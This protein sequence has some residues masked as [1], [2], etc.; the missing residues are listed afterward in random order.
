MER[1]DTNE[2]MVEALLLQVEKCL[3]E[4]AT[5]V[6]TPPDTIFGNGSLWNAVRLVDG[7]GVCLAAAHPRIS[8]QLM[9]ES[10]VFQGLRDLDTVIENDELV[11]L[12]FEY[13]HA[14]LVNAFDDQ[15]DNSTW[16]GLS[17]RKIS[18]NTYSVIH[19]LPTPYLANF[20]EK[21]LEFF[22]K[23][24]TF[25]NWDRSWLRMLVNDC[26]VKF[27]GSSEL[28]FCVEITRDEA[29][30]VVPVR[31]HLLNNDKVHG[32]IRNMRLQNHVCNALSCAWVGQRH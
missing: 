5:M 12:A 26:R 32:S 21:D 3:V 9:Q 23:D 27:C 4:D 18:R 17:I 15:D 22:S 2:T 1:R 25:N 13:G 14:N 7:K 16:S 24:R 11:D 8:K 19:N 10:K 6:T 20:L 31:S 30:T 28:F 29:E